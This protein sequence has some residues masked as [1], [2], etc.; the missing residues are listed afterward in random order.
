M[1][2]SEVHT[3]SILH[4]VISQK[5]I[6]LKMEA[7]IPPRDVGYEWSSNM[8]HY[9][10]WCRIPE[11]GLSSFIMQMEAIIPSETSV[12]KWSSKLQYY[13]TRCRIPEYRLSSFILK[14]EAIIP[15]KM[16]VMKWSSFMQY[17]SKRCHIP[18]YRLNS[19]ILQMEAIIPFKM[20][21][22]KWSSNMQYYSPWRCIPSGFYDKSPLR[23]RMV[24]E[25]PRHFW[26]FWE[27]DT[28]AFVVVC[29]YQLHR[30]LSQMVL[31]GSQSMSHET[32]R[33]WK[34]FSRFRTQWTNI[35]I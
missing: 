18:E 8:Q 30:C 14:M 32:L 23:Y 17:Y 35:V 31:W 10:T 24:R 33:L 6:L 7:I 29:T 5:I 1:L 20:S 26:G 25:R 19:F 9:S 12:I 28:Y 16:S 3:C 11:Y 34:G 15:S 22:M 27:S 2:W 21:V 4:G 13:S